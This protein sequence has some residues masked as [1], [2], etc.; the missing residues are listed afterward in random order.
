MN[1]MKL[2]IMILSASALSLTML[3]SGGCSDND[4]DVRMEMF[5]PD[6]G[7]LHIFLDE[8]FFKPATV[9]ARA[10]YHGISIREGISCNII[11]TSV[12]DE[13]ELLVRNPVRLFTGDPETDAVSPYA[14]EK[15]NQCGTYD[16]IINADGNVTTLKNF[17]YYGQEHVELARGAGWRVFISRENWELDEW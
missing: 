3:A 16:I 7:R 8:P 13:H 1:I 2:L 6:Y 4:K 12:D 17:H 5:E 14:Q 10:F 9:S 15:V 11:M